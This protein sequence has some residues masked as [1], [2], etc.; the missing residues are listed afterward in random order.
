MLD[1]DELWQLPNYGYLPRVAPKYP[2]VSSDN[3]DVVCFLLC[4]DHYFIDNADET[5]WLL[6][7]DTRSKALLSVTRRDT[8][9]SFSN[10]PLPAKLSW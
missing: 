10:L 4:E 8:T 3:H 6:E 1:C 9:G 5:V 2:I 7:I